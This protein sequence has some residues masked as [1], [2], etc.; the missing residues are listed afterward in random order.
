[1]TKRAAA[2]ILVARVY[3]PEKGRNGSRILVDRM[4][5]RGLKKEGLKIDGWMKRV[6]PSADLRRW[7]QHDPGRWE[8]F[9]RRYFAELDSQPDA[10]RELAEL[11]GSRTV[12]LLFAA[13]DRE[14]NNATALR[15]Y[16]ERQRRLKPAVRRG[17]RENKDSRRRL[18]RSVPKGHP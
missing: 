17:A 7:F 10:W 13:K 12:T 1:M 15:E 6:A 3:D 8:E 11:C 14:H 9:R 2:R 5:P 16:L 4:W 18:L